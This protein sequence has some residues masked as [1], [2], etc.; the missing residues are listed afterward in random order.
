MKFLSQLSN[1]TLVCSELQ[2]KHYKELLKCSFGDEPNKLIF[3]ETICDICSALTN[4]PATYFKKIS[5]TDLF[6]LILDIRINSI[7]DICKIVVTKDEKQMN[8]DLRLDCIQ[9][10]IKTIY[11]LFDNSSI[12]FN[13]FEIILEYPSVERLLQETE[14]EYL[15]FINKIHLNL[16][17]QFIHLNNKEVQLLFDKI[18]PNVS[19]KII[20][21]FESVINQIS[22][23]NFLSRY[24]IN[25][26]QL[27]FF[28]S[29]DSL[30]WFTKLIFS[31]SL[32]T[33]YDNLFYLSHLGHLNAEY[34]ENSVVG[35]YNYFITCL[36]KV[37]AVK[38][39]TQQSPDQFISDE[40]AGFIEEPV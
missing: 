19:L 8:L 3:V 7:G 14:E 26:Q 21:T 6:C 25:T 32:E 13:N 15:Y 2:V 30:I 23:K 11:S 10:E 29:L 28:P 5:I 9:E 16:N 31:E 12:T 17:N 35:E 37:L 36:Q 4:K 20:K 27:T 33:F 1:E 18:P 34:V 22:N 40:E 39:N 24:G 38:N